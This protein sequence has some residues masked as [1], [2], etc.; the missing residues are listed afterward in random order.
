MISAFAFLPC[1][2]RGA[3]IANDA[4][5]AD[6]PFKQRADGFLAL[7]YLGHRQGQAVQ[8]DITRAADPRDPAGMTVCAVSILMAIPILSPIA[9]SVGM[10][11]PVKGQRQRGNTGASPFIGREVVQDLLGA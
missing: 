1:R 6:Q 5:C 9:V 11:V 8:L 2:R 10:T 4:R 7:E 3:Q